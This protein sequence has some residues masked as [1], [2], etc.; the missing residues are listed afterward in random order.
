MIFHKRHL[1][2]DEHVHYYTPMKRFEYLV[3]VQ[4]FPPTIMSESDSAYFIRVLLP[5]LESKD[6]TLKLKENQLLLQGKF[7]LGS[8][9][10]LRKERP[11]H[12]FSR[13]YTFN[14]CIAKDSIESQ[15]KDGML[16]IKLMKEKSEEIEIVT[17]EINE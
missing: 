11:L 14:H 5:C 3:G 13:V 7:S 8:C 9:R 12:H 10:F 6:F 15:L 4:E 17:Q 2:S 1:T 16:F